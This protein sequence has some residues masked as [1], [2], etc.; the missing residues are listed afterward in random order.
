MTELDYDAPATVSWLNPPY[1]NDPRAIPSE[2]HFE[3][4]TFKE[5]VIFAMNQLNPGCREWVTIK[6]RGKEYKLAEIEAIY[7]NA[8]FP[9]P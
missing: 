7:R 8:R 5:A 3:E 2:E 1:G 4:F 9:W 6:C